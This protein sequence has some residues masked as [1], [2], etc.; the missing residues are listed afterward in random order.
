[1]VPTV[2][3]GE[4]R[5]CVWKVDL[6]AAVSSHRS[7]EHLLSRDELNH[8]N[9]LLTIDSRRRY[10]AG[11]AELRRLLAH[12]LGVE[13]ASLRFTYGPY[14]KPRLASPSTGGLHFNVSH[15]HGLMLVAVAHDREVGVDV[16]RVRPVSRAHKIARRSFS[17]TDA[18]RLACDTASNRDREFMMMWTRRE[19]AVKALGTGI[20]GSTRSLFD[21]PDPRLW[22]AGLEPAPSYV[23]A[24]ALLGTSSRTISPRRWCSTPGTTQLDELEPTEQTC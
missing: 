6:H 21:K 17:R 3:P 11:R 16:E 1:M 22:V 13:P 9:R 10:F 4:N 14:G 2:H 23:G 19:A 12:H 5:V 8:G 20:N 24:V 7:L 18:Q 15:S